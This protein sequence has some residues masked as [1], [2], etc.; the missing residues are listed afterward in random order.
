MTEEELKAAKEAEEAELLRKQN[1]QT[2][3]DDEDQ[4]DLTKLSPEELVAR[5]KEKDQLL[6]QKT[7]DADKWKNRA[8]KNYQKADEWTKQTTVVDEDKIKEI[9]RATTHEE[10]LKTIAVEKY[11][12]SGDKFKEVEKLR[13]EKNLSWDDAAK[14]ATYDDAQSNRNVNQHNASIGMHGTFAKGGEW[15]SEIDNILGYDPVIEKYGNK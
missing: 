1:E 2:E 4:D 13:N 15:G 3:D 6:A 12:L 7:L 5:I 10:T 9:V 11:Q 14:L 8:K